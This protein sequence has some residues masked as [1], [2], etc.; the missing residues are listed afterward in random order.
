[1]LLASDASL[2]VPAYEVVG[3]AHAPAVLVLGGISSHA[4][5]SATSA[6]PTPGWWNSIVGPGRAVDTHAFRVVSPGFLDG[7]RRAGGRPARTVTTRDQADAIAA[8]LDELEVSRLHAVVGAS[9]GGMVGLAIAERHPDRVDRLVVIGAAHRTHPMTA[10]RRLIQR[11]IVELGLET[12]RTRDAL[13]LAR[14][15]AMTTYRSATEF[16]QRFPSGPSGLP[17][18][19]SYLAHQGATFASRFAAERFL[20]LS[21]SSDLHTV[22]PARITTPTTIVA[23]EGD[24]VV[25]R[26]D[27]VELASALA[28]PTRL[29]DLP[30]RHGHDGFLTEPEA[31]GS[32]LSDTLTIS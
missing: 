28:G 31:L 17:A 14:A 27:L 25:P 30:T 18:I 1:M 29:L 6:D 32:I 9:Y 23:A 7:G 10:A 5:V 16:E 3:P 22:D 4:H 19:E 24:G 11:Q 13:A 15:L 20:A 26:A 21:L 2:D 12:G 8:L